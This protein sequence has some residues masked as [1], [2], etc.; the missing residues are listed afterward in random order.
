MEYSG[1]ERITP[2]PLTQ[3]MIRQLA[4]EAGFRALSMGEL[5]GE[6]VRATIKNNLVRQVLDPRAER[7]DPVRQPTAS[8]RERKSRAGAVGTIDGF[9]WEARVSQAFMGFA[10]ATLPASGRGEASGKRSEGM[11]SPL[12]RSREQSRSWWASRV[13]HHNPV[14]RRVLKSASVDASAQ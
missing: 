1:G 14:D 5:V 6:L 7:R 10:A 12:V 4:L 11:G 9:C 8:Q 13:P 2:L 3:D